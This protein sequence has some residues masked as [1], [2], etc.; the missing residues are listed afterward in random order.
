M[1]EDCKSTSAD[2]SWNEFLIELV[3]KPKPGPNRRI[4]PYNMDSA[5]WTKLNRVARWTN[6]KR[7]QTG[8]QSL[9]VTSEK[10][11]DLEKLG[12]TKANGFFPDESDDDDDKKKKKQWL[13]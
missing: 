11:G 6:E 2:D 10:R 9:T 5:L 4:F 12:Y 8:Y 1:S 3:K 7:N 13:S